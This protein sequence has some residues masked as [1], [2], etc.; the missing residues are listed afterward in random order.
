MMKCRILKAAAA[1]SVVLMLAA[2]GEQTDE[3]K[4]PVVR[5]VLFVIAK[6]ETSQQSGFAGT[7]EPQFST[8][9]AFRVLGRLIQRDVDIGDFVKKDQVVAMIDPAQLDL[10]LQAAKADMA[11]AEAQYVNAQAT[12]DRQAR[13]LAMRSI[14]QAVYDSAKQGRDTAAAGLEKARAALKKA[15]DERGFAQLDPDFDGVVSAVNAEVGQVVAAGQSV[16]TVAR[17]DVREA[18]VDVPDY[19]AETVKDGDRFMI[20]LQADP[21][22]QA[23]GHVREIAPQADN[24]TRLRRVKITLDDAPEAFRLGTTITALRSNGNHQEQIALP[25]S[26]LLEQEGKT[27]VWVA[28]PQSQTVRRQPVEVISRTDTHFIAK[29]VEAGQRIVSAGVNSLQDGQKVKLPQGEQ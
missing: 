20:F 23:E 12:E 1:G 27:Y 16:L 18:V 10:N 8:D 24:A 26:A 25:V 15:E 29:G 4:E 19:I 7:V 14:P 17:P 3:A 21:T 22:V 28:D 13:L 5:P 11:S 6:A 2:C 9:L